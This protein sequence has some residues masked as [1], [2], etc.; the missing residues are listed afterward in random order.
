MVKY[1]SNK[2]LIRA[3][4][5][6]QTSNEQPNVVNKELALLL[7][8][9]AERYS[10][11]ANWRNYSFRDEMVG[12]ALIHLMAP[13]PKQPI[14][15]ALRFD[16]DR[17]RQEAERT[18]Q[19]AKQVNPLAYITEIIKNNFIRTLK[20][21]RKHSDIRDT[22]LVEAGQAPSIGFQERAHQAYLDEEANPTPPKLKRGRKATA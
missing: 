6:C 22:M 5:D 19:P 17:A 21:E 11:K 18:G 13:G 14:P 4:V 7:L 16:V 2:D 8:L 10:F 3:I 1:V 12:N 9:I 15:P 20:M